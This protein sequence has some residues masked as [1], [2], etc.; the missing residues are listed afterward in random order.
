MAAR[1]SA[2]ISYS[3]RDGEFARRLQRRLEA[4]R[5]PR[6]LTA[7]GAGL[8]PDDRRLLP[9]FRDRDELTA[10]ADLT[11]A[12][13]TALAEASYLIVVCSPGSAASDWVGR[14][15]AL[16]RELH[17]ARRILC[18]L[19]AGEP[20]TAIPAALLTPSGNGQVNVPLAADFRPRGDGERLALLK[21]VAVM[22]DLRL[23]ELVQ[24]D[25]HRRVQ[26]VSALAAGAMLGMV[27]AGGLAWAA[28]RAR[29][30]AEREQ[31]RSEDLVDYMLTDLRE[32]LRGV[33]RLDLLDA[34]NKGALR[35]FAGQDLSKLPAAELLQRAQL[36]QA[37]GSDDETRGDLAGGMAQFIEAA[38]TTA[39]LVADRPDDPVR[40][41]AHADSEYYVGFG[42]WRLGDD[43]G[44]YDAYAGYA[45]LARRLVDIAPDDPDNLDED[46]DADSNLATFALHK[47]VD[48]ATALPL[49]LKAQSDFLEVARKKP[50][51]PRIQFDIADGYAW[52]ADTERLAGD[53][54]AALAARQQ[55]R[56]IIEALLKRDPDNFE[57]R[58]YVLRNKLGRAR[59][60]AATGD[61][62]AAAA[63]LQEAHDEAAV[64][65]HSEPAND[66]LAK[67]ARA[68][69][70]FEVRTW[71]SMPAGLAARPDRAVIV[72]TL[73]DCAA[74]Q[75][76]PNNGELAAFCT[77]QQARLAAAG[78][79]KAGAAKLLTPLHLEKPQRFRLTD[80]WL[81]D[82]RAEAV[83]N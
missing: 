68:V 33:G 21:L 58:F 8:R 27:V 44:A 47:S 45:R 4:Y 2:F 5:L 26:Q 76:K 83:L 6:H 25:A 36:L 79:D 53:T 20:E 75:A 50:D 41:R 11:E 60:I 67:Q 12:V 13:R 69:E 80:R 74:E 43:A 46:G 40:I 7:R 62:P 66:D 24:R 61:L 10:S 3:H 56:A 63:L 51:F 77:I 49:F 19:H 35:Y 82:L 1:Y 29:A 22:A 52:I 32:R 17:G 57:T 55:Q 64:L 59:I 14:E 48:T 71:L 73:R 38:R 70:L 30:A 15:V 72:A 78:G 23:D 37:I 18:A 9:V 28:V 65:C 39:A 81:L 34:V 42:K 31:S 54:G 16:F